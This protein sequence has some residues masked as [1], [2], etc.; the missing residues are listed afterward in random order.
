MYCKKYSHYQTL[1]NC[2]S[3][4]S[5]EIKSIIPLHTKILISV[6][7]LTVLEDYEG[8]R[9]KAAFSL[10][11][12]QCSVG[13]QAVLG[14][15]GTGTHIRKHTVFSSLL[16]ALLTSFFFPGLTIKKAYSTLTPRINNIVDPKCILLF[17]NFVLVHH[18]NVFTLTKQLICILLKI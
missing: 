4:E 5:N 12:T 2:T 6:P 1:N 11:Q 15:P 8:M 7:L 16:I 3:T 13:Q 18:P 14:S 9:L 10:S 17:V